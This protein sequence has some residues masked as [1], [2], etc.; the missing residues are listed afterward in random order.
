MEQVSKGSSLL[1]GKVKLL[2]K[3]TST[4]PDELYKVF[5]LLTPL[6]LPTNQLVIL[7]SDV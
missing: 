3:R 1:E 6:I 7:M 5:S 2:L 4:F